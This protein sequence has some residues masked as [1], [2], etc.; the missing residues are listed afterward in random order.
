LQRKLIGRH[1][2]KKK[3]FAFTMRAIA[4]YDLT[5]IGDYIVTHIPAMAASGIAF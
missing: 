5:E 3:A 2:G 4:F 1:K